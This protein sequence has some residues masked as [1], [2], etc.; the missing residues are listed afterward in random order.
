MR[1]KS[2]RELAVA[3]LALAL[4]GLAASAACKSSNEAPKIAASAMA[5]RVLEVKGSVTVAGKP[6]AAGDTV[7][8]G[9]TIDT[10]ADGSVVI[11]LAHNL[12]RWELGPN[13]HVRVDESLAWNQPRRTEPS[14]QVEQDTASAGRPAERNA[15]DT[16]ATSRDDTSA[17]A[18]AQAQAAASEHETPA[19]KVTRP[20]KKVSKSGLGALGGG[21]GTGGLGAGGGGIGTGAVG[22]IGKGGG[23]GTGYGAGTGSLRSKGG[24]APKVRH[25]KA[26]VSGSL[27]PDLV[28]R[29][30]RMHSG[31]LKYCYEKQL[32]VNPKLEGRV[33]V[34]FVIDSTGKVSTATDSGSA[35]PD[36]EVVSCVVRAFLTFKFPAPAGGDTV[37]VVYPITF[38]RGQP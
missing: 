35:M 9:D 18:P 8:P 34:K 15:M 4:S 26:Q 19:S 12:A 2:D 38:A 16:V 32:S 31:R 27:A 14:M 17:D 22:T 1:R 37:S 6:L 13:K 25:G 10:G 20:K 36:T 23:T 33:L 24:S 28:R 11:E 3:L 7:A 5:G 30:V 29:V 21:M